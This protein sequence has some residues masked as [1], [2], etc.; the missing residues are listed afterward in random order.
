[1]SSPTVYFV[2]LP[3]ESS[4]E[5]RLA[6]TQRILE[7][8]GLPSVVAP[9]DRTAVK[10]HVGE[11][12]NTTHVAPAIVR[13]VVEA[14]KRAGGSPFLTE[15]STL[16]KG[17]RSNA[18]DHLRQAF[19][20]GFGFEAIGAPFIMADGLTG[21]SE[22]EVAIK[23]E[24]FDRVAVAREVLL[25]DSLLAVTHATGH[26]GNGL[27]A[28][29]KNL[30]MGLASRMGKLRQHSSLKPTVDPRACTFC[31][32]CLKWCPAE[33]IVE[34]GGKAFIV[35]EVCIGCGEC[36]AVC[37]FDAVRHDWGPDIELLQRREAEHA[38]GVIQDKRDKLLV[39][40]YLTDMTKDCDCMARA[41]E[42]LQPD[43]GV[44][45]CR[46][47]VAVDQAALDLTR[48]RFGSSLAEAGWPAIDATVQLAH[49]ERIG[50]G[51]RTYRL[52]PLGG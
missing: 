22:V 52:E 2:E 38:L 8:C 3:P 19:A 47:P 17:E 6:A 30:G 39:L 13:A 32:K 41:Q 1:M 9:R 23:G 34:R 10:I 44:L 4:L 12:H 5:Q 45:A 16:Y 18:V 15:T 20:H 37:R 49:G 7:A 51:S 50:L 46:D 40:S 43:L 42:R 36:L 28:A 26:L 11:K 24:L 35:S 33:A 29:I 27:G 31:A 21:N 48:E 25:A 14:V